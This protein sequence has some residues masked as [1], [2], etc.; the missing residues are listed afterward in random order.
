VSAYVVVALRQHGVLPCRL[1][2]DIALWT[3]LFAL[4]DEESGRC[5]GTLVYGKTGEVD[6]VES[7]TCR[8][9]V[10]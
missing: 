2:A 3:Y 8:H 1:K 9:K 6:V 7:K 5:D 4:G 10:T